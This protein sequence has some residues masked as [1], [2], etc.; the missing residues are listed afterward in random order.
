MKTTNSLKLIIMAVCLGCLINITNAQQTAGDTIVIP[1]TVFD[2]FTGTVL[3]EYDSIF[4]TWLVIEEKYLAGV[5]R[6]T[7][8][9][10][11]RALPY[12][13]HGDRPGLK[14]KN[15][16]AYFNLEDINLNPEHFRIKFEGNENGKY[17]TIFNVN[18]H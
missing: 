8:Q 4:D 10:H 15:G 5:N 12:N 6:V 14:S 2:E 3:N 16:R 11:K 9:D 1:Y 17:K 18:K 7:L 13:L